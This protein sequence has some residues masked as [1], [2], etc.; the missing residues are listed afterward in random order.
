MAARAPGSGSLDLNRVALAVTG[1]VLGMLPE[2]VELQLEVSTLGTFS[3]QWEC[4]EFLCV[5][6]GFVN[7]WVSDR[8]EQGY[9]RG[10]RENDEPVKSHVYQENN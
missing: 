1:E 10:K 4:S 5:S 8:R 3:K 6:E 9:H 7:I 2:I